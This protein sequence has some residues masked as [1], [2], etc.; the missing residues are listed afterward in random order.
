MRR[1][2]LNSLFVLALFVAQ[3][4]TASAQALPRN[5]RTDWSVNL[6]YLFGTQRIREAVS[7]AYFN[8]WPNRVTVDY[9]PG[10]WLITGISEI[11]PS[12]SFSARLSGSANIPTSDQD[13][14]RLAFT[15]TP[16][17]TPPPPPPIANEPSLGGVWPAKTTFASWEAAGLYH[18]ADD[19][20]YRLSVSAGFRYEWWHR[21]GDAGNRV[22]RD[23]LASSVPFLGLHAAISLPGW[24][25]RFEVIGSAFMNSSVSCSASQGALYSTYAFNAGRG[26]RV[27]AHL[28]GE[29]SITTRLLWGIT[30]KYTFEGLYG[31]ITGVIN[32]V[33]Q[34][35]YNGYL[36]QSIGRVGLHLTWLM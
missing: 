20:L 12:P 4:A 14:A 5:W 7:P 32:G 30:A 1:V 8:S 35:T 17:F 13:V 34:E 31:P 19:G 33:V 28:S 11:S 27:E 29:A 21:A 3:T 16:T 6:E 25:G 23:T 15:P 10:F 26:G 22:L 24:R 2:T 36:E 18:F 9:N